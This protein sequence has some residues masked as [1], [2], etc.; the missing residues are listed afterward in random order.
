MNRRTL[1]KGAG[2]VPAA[3]SLS[4]SALAA[5]K[6]PAGKTFVLV[7]GAWHNSLHWGRTAQHLAG[8]GHRVVCVDLPGHGLNARFSAAYVTGD[9]K[10]FATEPSPV[11]DVGLEDCASAV[12]DVLKSLQG[13]PRPILV[14]H[15]MGG[16]VITR[17]GE[18]APEQVGRL[19]YLSAY[20]PIRLKK[21]SLYDTLP[22]A[23]KEHAKPYHLGDP[24]ALGAVRINPRGDMQY[25]EGVHA[26][27]YQDVAFQDFLPFAFALTPDLPLKLWT[28]EIATTR[29]RWGRL[30]RTYLR[31]TLDR[32]VDIAL[33]DLM[34]REA[35]EFTPGNPFEQKT[36]ETSHSP[37]ASQPVR[38]AEL[39]ASLR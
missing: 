27:F 18:L 5:P 1:L 11:R 15:S 26:N 3:L 7:H 12:I 31:C 9:A 25:L 29:E 28:S 23:K 37:F 2:L 36:L 13:G 16:G 38:L 32:A 8:L 20:C 34:I 6:A 30:P 24:A 17:V 10:A 33:Q 22:E 19:V 4:T 14:G 39:L 21:P 35:D